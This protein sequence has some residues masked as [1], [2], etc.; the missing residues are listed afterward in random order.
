MGSIVSSND[1]T[2]TNMSTIVEQTENNGLIEPIANH[3]CQQKLRKK[4]MDLN[5]HWLPSKRRYYVQIWPLTKVRVLA[6]TI[7]DG[8]IKCDAIESNQRLHDS[9]VSTG[10]EPRRIGLREGPK[11]H[12]LIHP[13]LNVFS[14][15]GERT[16]GTMCMRRRVHH[17]SIH[18]NMNRRGNSWLTTVSL[19]QVQNCF[20]SWVDRMICRP[21]FTTENVGRITMFRLIDTIGTLS[22]RMGLK[23][24]TWL[25]LLRA[26]K[27]ELDS[28]LHRDKKIQSISM[29]ARPA[30]VASVM[31]WIGS[32]SQCDV[33]QDI[34]K[35]TWRMTWSGDAS[36]HAYQKNKHL[37]RAQTK[38][39]R[40]SVPMRLQRWRVWKWDGLLVG[41]HG[42]CN[43]VWPAWRA[44]TRP[45]HS[46]TL[47]KGDEDVV[48]DAF[49]HA[50][51]NS[52]NCR[53]KQCCER[54][55]A[56]SSQSGKK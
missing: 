39:S 38:R 29:V 43:C 40:A 36:L 5:G 48:E 22:D 2:S 16:K 21:S 49:E 51:W 3:T 27:S 12:G 42:V 44:G 13:N 9:Q 46:Q 11:K 41:I 34:Q 56:C 10:S 6:C 53:P 8:S 47:V 45:V 19:R 31:Q 30:V 17:R 50:V 25:L 4:P 7:K 15:S 35:I 1:D 55:T 52:L 33:L 26:S 18:N 28:L 24:A 32:V 23:P 54:C 14:A 37:L 20:A